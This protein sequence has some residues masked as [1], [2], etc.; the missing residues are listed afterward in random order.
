EAAL[1]LVA[2]V[3]EDRAARGEIPVDPVDR[4][5]RER[6]LLRGDGP[7]DEREEDELVALGIDFEGGGGLDRGAPVQRVGEAD[8]AGARRLVRFRVAGANVGETQLGRG[9]EEEALIALRP[10]GRR[11][12]EERQGKD[13]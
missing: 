7:V 8:E 13:R 6:R 3:E 11:G 10:S 12:R 9:L 1:A 4:P 5:R 2:R